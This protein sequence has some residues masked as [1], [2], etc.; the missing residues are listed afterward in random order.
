MK[1]LTVIALVVVALMISCNTQGIVPNP[2]YIIVTGE[3]VKFEVTGFM[4]GTH[5]LYENDTLRYALTS[6]KVNLNSYNNEDVNVQ[7]SIINGYPVDCGPVY[8]KVVAIELTE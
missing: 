2:D 1:K 7:C 3:I 8:L 4:Y 5:G 6:D